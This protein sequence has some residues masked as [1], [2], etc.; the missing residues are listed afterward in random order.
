M[1]ELIEERESPEQRQTRIEIGARQ[2][3]ARQARLDAGKVKCAPMTK[4]KLREVCAEIERDAKTRPTVPDAAEREALKALEP[5]LY[6]LCGANAKAMSKRLG[7]RADRLAE[8]LGFWIKHVPYQE[9]HDVL[10]S[11]SLA[12]MEQQPANIKLAF[13]VC[14]GYTCNWWDRYHIRQH[15]GLETPV[16]GAEGEVTE[17]GNTIA[18]VCQYERIEGEIDGALLW[19]RLPKRIRRI[20]NIKLTNPKLLT[21]ADKRE[22]AEYARKNASVLMAE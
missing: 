21:L 22:L 3:R 9:R 5:S 11:L 1:R 7:L 17:L 14:R 6:D 4:R 12:L 2:I 13:A 15:I 19:D 20:V 18:A 8:V 16:F 10:Q